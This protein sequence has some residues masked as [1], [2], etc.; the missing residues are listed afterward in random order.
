MNFPMLAMSL[1]SQGVAALVVV[2]T[3]MAAFSFWGRRE[4]AY[5]LSKHSEIESD[6][7]LTEFKAMVRQQMIVAIGVLGMGI[8]FMLL[9]MFV[10]MQLW[11]MGFLIVLLFSTPI[12][13]LA[14]DSKKLEN[15]ARTLACSDE[16]RRAEYT[17]VASAWTKQFFPDF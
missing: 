14:R 16:R 13:L 10:T 8:V 6:E 11:L 12:F 2:S 1:A 17:R 7:T 9:C 15:R 3:L 5:F 4:V